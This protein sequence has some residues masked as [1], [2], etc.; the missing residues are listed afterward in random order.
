MEHPGIHIHNGKVERFHWRNR[1][2]CDTND[3]GVIA[4]V[5]RRAMHVAKRNLATRMEHEVNGDPGLSREE[6][7]DCTKRKNAASSHTQGRW[8]PVG[9]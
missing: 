7:T 1:D 8:H 2:T 4:M 3:H 9:L 6:R 5:P